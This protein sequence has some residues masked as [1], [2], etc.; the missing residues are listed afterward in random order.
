V[1][2]HEVPRP[3]SLL[4]YPA[5]LDDRNRAPWV[6][7]LSQA[8]PILMRSVEVRY[9]A[10]ELYPRLV[11]TAFAWQPSNDFEKRT[12]AAALAVGPKNAL[13]AE[14]VVRLIL[15]EP[16]AYGLTNDLGDFTYY[17]PYHTEELLYAA[18]MVLLAKTA[19]EQ[20]AALVAF[21]L[22]RFRKARAGAG[23]GG[24]PVTVKDLKTATAILEVSRWATNP[25]L[26][27]YSRYYSFALP[28]C[29]MVDPAPFDCSKT[30]DPQSPELIGIMNK[31]EQWLATQREPLLKKA[32]VERPWLDSL[33][34]ELHLSI[35]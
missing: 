34:Q 29:K 16:L 18:N 24:L 17:V 5:T 22:E 12:R 14:T 7:Q 10:P 30:L 3:A 6:W 32:E 23:F 31:F 26:N 19:N 4:D 8:L 13:W 28:V 25:A 27:L 2:G 35:E 11:E 1:F 15:T 9:S 20:V 33:L 21:K